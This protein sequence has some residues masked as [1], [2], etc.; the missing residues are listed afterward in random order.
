LSDTSLKAAINHHDANFDADYGQIIAQEYQKQ[1][2]DWYEQYAW[3]DRRDIPLD[4]SKSDDR[5]AA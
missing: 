5:L 3:R 2:R 4:E 1:L